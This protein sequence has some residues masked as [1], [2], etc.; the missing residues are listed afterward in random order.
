MVL[1]NMG[2]PG[3][4]GANGRNAK[5]RIWNGASTGHSAGLSCCAV[6][7]VLARSA[8]VS[9]A[10]AAAPFRTFTCGILILLRWPRPSEGAMAAG[11]VMYRASGLLTGPKN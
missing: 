3:L 2:T 4:P 8:L 7:G 5:G 1:R 10:A 9:N 11:V 6:A